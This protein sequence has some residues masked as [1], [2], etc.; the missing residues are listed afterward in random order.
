MTG[1][2][3]RCLAIGFQPCQWSLWTGYQIY[4]KNPFDPR[5]N[6]SNRPS[7]FSS[8]E[9]FDLMIL[10]TKYRFHLAG[11]MSL[12]VLF[13]KNFTSAYVRYGFA[14]VSNATTTAAIGGSYGAVIATKITRGYQFASQIAFPIPIPDMHIKSGFDSRLHRIY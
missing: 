9:T 6:T 13:S 2:S 11:P 3:I 5:A 7:V 14:C 12:A 10:A 1:E 4:K 8:K